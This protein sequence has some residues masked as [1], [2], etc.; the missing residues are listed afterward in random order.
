M[1]DKVFRCR[2][3]AQLAG[4]VHTD[5]L[6]RL[7]LPGRAGHSVNSIGAANTDSEETETTG[8]W[9]VRV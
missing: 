8:V 5:D 7:Q 4:E 2:P 1:E 6:R 3:S 9:S